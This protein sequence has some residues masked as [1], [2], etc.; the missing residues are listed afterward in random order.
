MPNPSFV[1]PETP[2]QAPASRAGFQDVDTLTNSHGMVSIISQRSK[3]GELTFGIFRVWTDP[4]GGSQ[5]RTSF[6]PESLTEAFVML[7][8]LTI[9]R[10]KEL[11]DQGNLPFG[12]NGT[13]RRPQPRPHV[14]P[15]PPRRRR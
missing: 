13:Q 9:N 4:L 8:T 7:T 11:R 1:M 12:P 10:M 14:P 2:Q 3:T 15:R 5:N 6:I